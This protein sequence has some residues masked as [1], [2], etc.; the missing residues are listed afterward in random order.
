[1][2]AILLLKDRTLLKYSN[3]LQKG[4]IIIINDDHHSLIITPQ[5]HPIRHICNWFESHVEGFFEMLHLNIVNDV[6][7]N[8]RLVDR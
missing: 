2:K 1:M 4:L 6:D 3:N 5:D 8:A 7:G